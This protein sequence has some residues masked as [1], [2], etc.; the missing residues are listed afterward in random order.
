LR[1]ITYFCPFSSPKIM[2]MRTKK[3]TCTLIV[4]LGEGVESGKFFVDKHEKA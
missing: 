1:R 3:V 2:E 4:F